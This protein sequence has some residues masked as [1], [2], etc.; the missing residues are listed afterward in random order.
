MV[1][2]QGRI[3]FLV[4]QALNN[5]LILAACLQETSKY[6]NFID[7]NCHYVH[8]VNKLVIK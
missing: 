4:M 2:K 3:S 7:S 5:M 6:Y 8:L 1:E